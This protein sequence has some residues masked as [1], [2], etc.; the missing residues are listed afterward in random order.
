MYNRTRYH[1][2]LYQEYL[3]SDFFSTHMSYISQ[4]SFYTC[5]GHKLVTTWR[6]LTR[7]EKPGG[8]VT[9]SSLLLFFSAWLFSTLPQSDS[10]LVCT[11]VSTEH[12]IACNALHT[13]WQKMLFSYV[14][15]LYLLQNMK[16]ITA[17]TNR[18]CSTNLFCNLINLLQVCI[19]WLLWVNNCIN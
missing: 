1:K 15:L 18:K 7:A 5:R 11:S 9:V 4:H 13:G 14:M 19:I 10:V 8:L 12:K 16:Y 6:I 3:K 2:L 17:L